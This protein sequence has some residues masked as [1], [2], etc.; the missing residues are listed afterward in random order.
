M[1]KLF[2]IMSIIIVLVF[3]MHIK[4]Y[5]TNL[6][7]TRISI[8]NID[9]CLNKDS[10]NARNESIFYTDLIDDSKSFIGTPYLWGATGPNRFD[11]SGFIRYIWKSNGIELPRTS[12]NQYKHTR[13]NS[14][15]KAECRIGDLIFFKGGRRNSHL[16]VGHVGMIIS[17]I[18]GEINFIHASSGGVKITSLNNSSYYQKK[19]V[20]I[21]RILL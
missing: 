20:G 10:I 4:S 15:S 17:N 9:T 1:K 6:N 21:T 18:D 12:W 13:K 14:I 16:P 11:C 19:F 5:D 7:R 3:S 2:V 8:V